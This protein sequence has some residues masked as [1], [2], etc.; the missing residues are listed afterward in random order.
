MQ[1]FFGRGPIA[2]SLGPTFGTT[3]DAQIAGYDK[4]IS[5]NDML[6]YMLGMSDVARKDGDESTFEKILRMI[7]RQ[8]HKL[9]FETIPSLLAGDSIESYSGT[10]FRKLDY[11][12]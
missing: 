12:L 6:G 4:I 11:T 10:I 1:D 7:N 3:L 5:R 9:G 8:T 2:G